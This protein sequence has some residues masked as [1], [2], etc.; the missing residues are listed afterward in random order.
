MR[1]IEVIR[2][3]P[4]CINFQLR[5]QILR[6]FLQ[7]PIEDHATFNAALGVQDE[8]YLG[9]GGLVERSFDDGV[10]SADVGC[11]VGEVALDKALEDVE[12]Y[13]VAGCVSLT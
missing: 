11:C 6:H 9:Q 8:D 2:R 12:D 10:A 7:Q 5:K 13:A 1:V 4:E 3:I